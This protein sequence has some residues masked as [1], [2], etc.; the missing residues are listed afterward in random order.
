VFHDLVS[1]TEKTLATLP[2][3]TT[4]VLGLEHR[5][6]HQT[7]HTFLKGNLARK[8]RTKFRAFP[9]QKNNLSGE[10]TK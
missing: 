6:F 9:N 5:V 4:T 1:F 8:K 3:A 2:T 10:K 7:E